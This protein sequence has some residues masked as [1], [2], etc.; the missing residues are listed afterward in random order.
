MQL[1]EA[2][3]SGWETEAFYLEE[4]TGGVNFSASTFSKFYLQTQ[5]LNCCF[6]NVFNVPSKFLWSV[7][8]LVTKGPF[9]ANG[10]W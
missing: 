5:V 3:L 1:K 7:S 9:N 6:G 4:N 8:R 2:R 10:G